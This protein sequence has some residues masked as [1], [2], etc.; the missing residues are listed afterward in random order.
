MEFEH[1]P[2]HT[3]FVPDIYTLSRAWGHY[4]VINDTD[5]E[6]PRDWTTD[7]EAAVFIYSG[8]RGQRDETPDNQIAEAFAH[9]YDRLEDEDRALA[10]TQRWL[11]IF[12]PE[13]AQQVDIAIETITGYS[14]GDWARVFAAVQH[15]YGTAAGH[16]DQFRMWLFGDVWAVI[17]SDGESLHGIYAD[18]QEEALQV[19]LD[20][21]PPPLTSLRFSNALIEEIFQALVERGD[22]KAARALHEHEDAAFDAFVGPFL[23]Y[24]QQTLRGM[25]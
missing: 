8:P 1:T 14:Q 7:A 25:S 10:A 16:I 3:T 15:D 19:Y 24:L 4:S 9:F 13:I 11:A 17:A 18:T 12:H 21:N 20:Q 2:G 5:S 22:E 23:D 6:D